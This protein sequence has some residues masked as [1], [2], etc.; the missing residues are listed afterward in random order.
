MTQVDVEE[1][2]CSDLD[3]LLIFPTNVSAARVSAE[4][5]AIGEDSK[6]LTAVMTYVVQELQIGNILQQASVTL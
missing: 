6:K 1:L 3:T 4:L 5:C 2:V